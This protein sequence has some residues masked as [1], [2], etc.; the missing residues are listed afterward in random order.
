MGILGEVAVPKNISDLI[1][2]SGL[3]FTAKPLRHVQ[4]MAFAMMLAHPVKASFGRSAQEKLQGAVWGSAWWKPC[5]PHCND[6]Q[7]YGMECGQIF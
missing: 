5:Q 1:L 3:P 2:L 6:K 7:P 4:I